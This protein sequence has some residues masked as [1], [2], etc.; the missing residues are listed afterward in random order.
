M[1]ESWQGQ[2]VKSPRGFSVTNSR[3]FRLSQSGT[4]ESFAILF[5]LLCDVL[6]NFCSYVVD[7][8]R[9]FLLLFGHFVR[10][11]LWFFVV[12]VS[13]TLMH[14]RADG[15]SNLILPQSQPD[16]DIFSFLNKI[17]RN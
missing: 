2:L 1:F 5:E 4:C 6:L 11:V 10:L 3:D 7:W 12:I 8:T 15:M 17:Q 13:T 9:N 16:P 14:I